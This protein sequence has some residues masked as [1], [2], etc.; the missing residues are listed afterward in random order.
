MY[1]LQYYDQ[2]RLAWWN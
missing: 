1:M 2:Y